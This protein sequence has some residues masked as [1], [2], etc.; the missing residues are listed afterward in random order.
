MGVTRFLLDRFRE[1]P[2]KTLLL[3]SLALGAKGGDRVV[4]SS[5]GTGLSAR[6]TGDGPPVVMVHGALDGIGS[7]ALVELH[8][9]D[10]FGVWVYDRRGRGGSGDGANYSL[11]REVDDLRAVAAATG[12][13]PHVVGHSYGAV[14]A[15]SA[16]LGGMPMRS[17]VVYEPP[18]NPG[19]VTD[20]VIERIEQL[21]A[22]DRLD[23]AITT[24]A[25][26]LAGV[27]DDEMAPALRVPPIRATLR[28]GV[29]VVSRELRALQACDWSGLPVAGIPTLVLD[30]E[31]RG[32]DAYPDADQRA[33]LATDA[34]QATFA[35]QGH[36]ANTYAPVEFARVVGDF[37]ARH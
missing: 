20:D 15:L 18:I 19:P 14:I 27:T 30:G 23:D 7:F 28:A 34:E 29:R 36:L 37:L 3:R 16:A 22:E 13:T 17:L 24:M 1:A 10:R 33:R 2:S 25:R 11:D 26:D 8:L 5:D 31:R 12:E 32:S 9:A 35:G 4:E 6:R 21:V